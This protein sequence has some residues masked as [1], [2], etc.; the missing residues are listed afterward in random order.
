LLLPGIPEKLT[1]C[2][3]NKIDIS[4]IPGLIFSYSIQTSK[5]I[6][7]QT[8]A[9][10]KCKQNPAARYGPGIIPKRDPKESS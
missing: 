7:N 5:S 2:E 1:E 8:T 3:Y 9:T 4:R 10:L 6:A